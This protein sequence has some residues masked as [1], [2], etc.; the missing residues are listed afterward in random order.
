[1]VLDLDLDA[2][3][4]RLHDLDLA[5][6]LQELVVHLGEVDAHFLGEDG[7]CRRRRRGVVL[8]PL[9]EHLDA[10]LDREDLVGDVLERGDHDLTLLGPDAVEVREVLAHL[11]LTLGDAGEDALHVLDGLVNLADTLLDRLGGHSCSASDLQL[12]LALQLRQLPAHLEVQLVDA[13]HLLLHG[14]LARVAAVEVLVQ[15]PDGRNDVAHEAVVQG[16]LLLQRGEAPLDVGLLG[17]HGGVVAEDQASGSRR[18]WPPG[19]PWRR[20]R[21]ELAAD[22]H[23][24]PSCRRGGLSRR[25]EVLVLHTVHTI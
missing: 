8:G 15:A 16:L 13:L 21:P 12:D 6:D 7:R 24:A 23:D 14:L 17:D 4:A 20:R 11:L 2:A 1:M 9:L 22:L 10:L 19:A 25:V 5:V 18:R 3:D